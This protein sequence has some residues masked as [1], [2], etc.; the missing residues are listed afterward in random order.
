LRITFATRTL[1]S[2]VDSQI[3]PWFTKISL[4]R[5]GSPQLGPRAPAGGGSAEFRR[6]GGR[7]QWGEGGRGLVAH[8]GRDLHAQR[9][10]KAPS[11]GAPAPAGSG[12]G[13]PGSGVVGLS[14]GAWVTRRATTRVEEGGG[15]LGGSRPG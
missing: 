15:G 14:W 13:L 8:L 4:E 6:G 11:G 10:R 7:N 5:M 3:G 1:T 9:G 12:R 2:F